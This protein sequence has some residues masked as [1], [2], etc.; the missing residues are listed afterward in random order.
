MPD[1]IIDG[2]NRIPSKIESLKT[3][4][5]I[6]KLNLLNICDDFQSLFHSAFSFG[7]EALSAVSLKKA[8]RGA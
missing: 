6:S 7:I 4:Y 8:N 2:V 5:P 3:F 1:K